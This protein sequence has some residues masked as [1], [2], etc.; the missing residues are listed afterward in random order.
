MAFVSHPFEGVIQYLLLTVGHGVFH[1]LVG[2]VEAGDAEV[3]DVRM[4]FVGRVG[5][6][7]GVLIL[8][9]GIDRFFRGLTGS[10]GGVTGGSVAGVSSPPQAASR[11]RKQSRESLVRI[12]NLKGIKTGAD[13]ADHTERDKKKS[14]KTA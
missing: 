2:F 4:G 11:N 6:E 3:R 7:V 8:S 1:V 13:C 9:G 10:S 12:M 14:V 5:V